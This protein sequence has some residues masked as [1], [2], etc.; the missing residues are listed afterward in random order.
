[1]VLKKTHN[2]DVSCLFIT[3]LYKLKVAEWSW[4]GGSGVDGINML[5]TAYLV[6]EGGL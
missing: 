4:R 5:I 2:I 3:N 6:E 1:M